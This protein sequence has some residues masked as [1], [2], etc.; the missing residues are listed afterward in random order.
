MSKEWK[1]GRVGELIAS[2]ESGI[3]VNGEDGTPS[4]DDYAVLKVSAV[5]YGK[6]NPQASKK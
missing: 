4:N 5:T 6:F 3:S 2:L 1:N